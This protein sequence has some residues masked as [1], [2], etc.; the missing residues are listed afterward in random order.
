MT[1][2]II[3]SQRKVSAKNRQFAYRYIDYMSAIHTAAECSEGNP[4]LPQFS[5]NPT[6]EIDDVPAVLKASAEPHLD[7]LVSV[8]KYMAEIDKCIY[9]T[10]N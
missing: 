5:L 4:A 10:S 8:L 9:Q 1:L 3:N 7:Y 2:L 6:Y